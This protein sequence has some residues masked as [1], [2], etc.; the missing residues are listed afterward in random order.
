MGRRRKAREMALQ[1]LYQIDVAKEPCEEALQIFWSFTKGDEKTQEFCNA[2]VRGT[3]AHL[4]AIDK[5]LERV[6]DH[7][8][9]E[10]MSIVDRNIL[11]FAIYEL[12]YLKDIPPK[13]TIN[14]AIEIAKK[15]GAADSAVFVN[16]ILDRVNQEVHGKEYLSLQSYL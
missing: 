1:V 7:W 9:L 2:L 10:R 11:R 12:C 6:S 14:E 15:Y 16:G 5:I 4:P 13:V 3:M 8:T